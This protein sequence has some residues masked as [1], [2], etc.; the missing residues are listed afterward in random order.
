MAVVL[1]ERADVGGDEEVRTQRLS[2]RRSLT[3][4]AL[5]RAGRSIGQI[6][7][8]AVFGIYG[9]LMS[10]LLVPLYS[11]VVRDR[12]RRAHGIRRVVHYLLRAYIGLMQALRLID[13]EVI[14]LDRVPPPGSLIV[15]NH[16]SL[17][18][19][20]IL[21]AHIDGG[22]VVA[23]RS[24]QIN[25]FTSAAIRGANYV[26]NDDAVALIDACRNRISAGESLVLFPECTRTAA[27]GVIR[28][29]RGAAQ[30]AVRS[31]C[32]VIPVTIEFS[33]PLLTKESR[34]WMAPK[35]RPR[36]RVVGHTPIDP[37]QFLQGHHSVSLAAR[38][39][40]EHL[41]VLYVKELTRCEPA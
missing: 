27:D 31:G 6:A 3:V 12:V 4:G 35:V 41:R 34:W 24:L 9:A 28:L 10:A 26:V 2:D 20:L 33:E 15:A 37:A 13:L 32:S 39:L 23:K 38:R 21:L 40:T 18:D 16:P 17:I 5:D 30:I 8:F 14:G 7:L 11:V 25:P 22:V 19:A 1:S 36:V 29:R